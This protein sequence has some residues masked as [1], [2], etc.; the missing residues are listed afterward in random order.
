MDT[1]TKPPDR[2]PRR[3]S[4]RP[5]RSAATATPVVPGDPV[6]DAPPVPAPASVGEGG[7]STATAG[8]TARARAVRGPARP[9]AL[10]DAIRQSEREDG[11]RSRY[12]GRS[13]SGRD[14]GW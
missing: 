1:P 6:T 5:A 4:R 2:P 7:L 9:S 3:Q 12:G 13:R 10:G 14:R 8:Q 11:A